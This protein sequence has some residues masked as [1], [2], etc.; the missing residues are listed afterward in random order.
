MTEHAKLMLDMMTLAMQT[1]STRV[2]SFMF[3]NAGSNRGY[4]DLQVPEGHHDLSHHGKAKRNKKRSP[5]SIDI[6]CHSLPT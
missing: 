6:I 5:L 3:T 2:I 1:D 4:P